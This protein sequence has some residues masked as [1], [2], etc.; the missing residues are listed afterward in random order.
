MKMSYCRN[1][2]SQYYSFWF[3]Y[4]FGNYSIVRKLDLNIA[5]VGELVS[6]IHWRAYEKTRIFSLIFYNHNNDIYVLKNRTKLESVIK[7]FP[8]PNRSELKHENLE[9]V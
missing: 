6:F 3:G 7:N 8:L 1:I 4:E 2:R 5:R 9:N